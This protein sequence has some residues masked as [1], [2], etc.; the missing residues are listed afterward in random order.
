[1]LGILDDH[2]RAAPQL[3]HGAL[4]AAQGRRIGPLDRLLARLVEAGYGG[5]GQGIVWQMRRLRARQAVRP[6]PQDV[7]PRPAA[8]GRPNRRGPGRARRRL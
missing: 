4:D 3:A 6:L 8:Q 5:L 2:R 7:E 1:M